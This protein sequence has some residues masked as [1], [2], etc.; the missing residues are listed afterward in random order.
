MLAKAR[1]FRRID[2]V[3][4]ALVLSS[5]LC[6]RNPLKLAL[7]TEVSLKLGKDPQQVEERVPFSEAHDKSPDAEALQSKGGLCLGEY[8]RLNRIQHAATDSG[9]TS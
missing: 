6:V 5:D 2:A 4:S 3:F 7:S 9:E 1:H 8:D